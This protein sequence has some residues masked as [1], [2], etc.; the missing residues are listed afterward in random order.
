MALPRPTYIEDLKEWQVLQK[1]SPLFVSDLKWR[2]GEGRE[3][4]Q[5]LAA[6]LTS[7][8]SSLFRPHFGSIPAGVPAKCPLS[9]RTRAAF[10]TE[11]NT[12]LSNLEL[13][14]DE[15]VQRGSTNDS[16]S[17]EANE[18]VI[19]IERD[20]YGIKPK[21]PAT[22]PRYDLSAKYPRLVALGEI[23]EMR[24]DSAP[25]ENYAEYLKLTQDPGEFKEKVNAVKKFNESIGR[26]LS[27][28]TPTPKNRSITKSRSLNIHSRFDHN[29]WNCSKRL[30]NS[31]ASHL[32]L[33]SAGDSNNSKHRAMLHLRNFQR[34]KDDQNEEDRDHTS[35]PAL[36][37][38][39]VSCPDQEK[40]Q[41]TRCIVSSESSQFIDPEIQNLCQLAHELQAEQIL[42][43]QLSETGL[44]NASELFFGDA[45]LY[46]TATPTVSFLDLLKSDIVQNR[47]K[48][49]PNDKKILAFLLSHALLYLNDG[50]WLQHH[51]TPE[52]IKFLRDKDKIYDIHHP[53]I[54]CKL[55]HNL[56]KL[57][58]LH[59]LHHY[60][61]ILSF[62]RLLVEL[63]MG[64]SFSDLLIKLVEAGKLELHRQ[65]AEPD[66]L[67]ALKSM[68][69]G[70]GKDQLNPGYIKAL[71]AC[72]FFPKLFRQYQ[73]T[74]PE[75][76]VEDVILSDIVGPL[77]VE[78]SISKRREWV[79][80]HLTVQSGILCHDQRQASVPASKRPQHAPPSASGSRFVA[81]QQTKGFS[82]SSTRL[83]SST[84]TGSLSTQQQAL[85]LLQNRTPD[86]LDAT[87]KTTSK[88]YERGRNV[89]T[90]AGGSA[91]A[92]SL[93]SSMSSNRGNT[94]SQPVP[95][96]GTS[97]PS[98][99]MARSSL[100]KSSTPLAQNQS[101]RNRLMAQSAEGP[102]IPARK[103]SPSALAIDNCEVTSSDA[104]DSKS[105]LGAPV[106]AIKSRSGSPLLGIPESN[107]KA[108][109]MSFRYLEETIK[110]RLQY[111]PDD[112][113]RVRIAVLDTGLDDQHENFQLK[114]TD[115]MGQQ[116]RDSEE[117]T[118]RYGSRIKQ[119]RNFC[120][121]KPEDENADVDDL[122]GHGTQIAGVLLR[123]APNADIYVARVCRGRNVGFH[124]AAIKERIDRE[125]DFK[126]PEPDV[127]ARAIDWAIK[128]EVHIINL[129]LGFRDCDYVELEGLT[130]ALERAR[131]K[132]LVFAATSNEGGFE[133]AAWPAKDPE[134]AIGIHSAVDSGQRPSKL[135]ANPFHP[136]DNFM[137]VGENIL[138]QW[139]TRKGG[140]CR[141]CSGSSFATP[142][143]AAMGALLLAFVWQELCAQE[144]KEAR[145]R[146]PVDEIQTN[147]GMSKVL[148]AISKSPQGNAAYRS[149][150][151]KLLWEDYVDIGNR[152]NAKEA[153]VHAW[154]VIKTALK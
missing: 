48:F 6:I 120:C 110:K 137:V 19:T 99:S 84:G 80:P 71:K 74:H 113:R 125:N 60:P 3:G 35:P 141:L 154:N 37:L 16:T 92:S 32:Q 12:L 103:A 79:S 122:D 11:I 69:T 82:T 147:K 76:T 10:E 85:P 107:C 139:P 118:A 8:S 62:A 20:D 59:P 5:E 138:S 145:E 129:S 133:S 33:C 30:F 17:N 140:G 108:S 134:Y 152:N 151:C 73:Q 114:Q 2:P 66:V 115:E 38:L 65:D 104:T 91:K 111:N 135:A 109:E 132:I 42:G 52:G 24:Q 96:S 7:E 53:Y 36:T 143:A 146:V 77:E 127:V 9:E 43:V 31:L 22:D 50:G 102:S 119:R 89:R 49:P 21:P 15:A 123:L 29:L 126:D 148:R 112:D 27:D 40:W 39:L 18:S 25:V 86:K 23:L 97:V 51:W 26:I 130:Q 72:V 68:C 78:V 28:A 61:R 57:E 117:N 47:Y 90:A 153:R 64:L 41:Q 144:R 149:I 124:D 67:E 94:T 63:E 136:G 95:S 75:V 4:N 106:I 70:W 55:S 56:P 150:S 44:L 45:P 34:F 116:N 87:H 142:V 46:P 105:K 54:A 13:L 128:E 58:N 101:K 83:R 93:S 131:K 100:S 81:K 121:H 88:G 98:P 1:V 14:V